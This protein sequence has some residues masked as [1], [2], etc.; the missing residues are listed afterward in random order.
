MK[1]TSPKAHW[2]TPEMLVLTRGR[3][4]E[5]VLTG[6]KMDGQ[7][8]AGVAHDNCKLVVS[9]TRCQSRCNVRGQS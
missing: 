9:D 8:G 4:E 3:P 1:M 6:C 7:S 2:K 5:S